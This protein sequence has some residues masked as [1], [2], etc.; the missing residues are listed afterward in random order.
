MGIACGVEEKG[1]VQGVPSDDEYSTY[2]I[3]DRYVACGVVNEIGA[4]V[5]ASAGV[6][7]V[8]AVAVA[9]A[10]VPQQCLLQISF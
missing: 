4:V 3:L 6:V 8:A 1:H 2:G 9:V 7:V 5:G 10:V